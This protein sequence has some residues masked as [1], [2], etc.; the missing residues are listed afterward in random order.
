MLASI[1]FIILRSSFVTIF[2]AGFLFLLSKIRAP[3]K[4]LTKTATAY[5]GKPY[6]HE[7]YQFYFLTIFSLKI[8]F[9]C[10]NSIMKLIFN[11]KVVEK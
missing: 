3:T 2:A 10:L 7:T 9:K 6:I 8:S 4:I 11:K 5:A 1:W